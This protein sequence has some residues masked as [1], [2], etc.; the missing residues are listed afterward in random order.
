MGAGANGH[1]AIWGKWALGKNG[2]WEKRVQLL[3]HHRGKWVFGAF[4]W[5]NKNF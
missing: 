4:N 5:T 1:L 2:F 3:G